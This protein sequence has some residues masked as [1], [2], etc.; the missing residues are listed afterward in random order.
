MPWMG[1]PPS[2]AW[3]EGSGLIEDFIIVY[4]QEIKYPELKAA[5]VLGFGSHVRLP[6]THDTISMIHKYRF[7]DRIS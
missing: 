4:F 5:P 7:L 2:T 6:N 3:L 1:N